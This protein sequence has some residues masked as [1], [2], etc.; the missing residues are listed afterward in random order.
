MDR[1]ILDG[2]RIVDLSEGRAGSLAALMLAEAGADVVKIVD[3]AHASRVTAADDAFWNRSK[4]RE[5]LDLTL[6]ADRRRLDTLLAGADMLIHDRIPQDAAALGLDDATLAQARPDLIVAGV[7][8]W[9]VGHPLD[10]MATDDALALA[11]AGFFDEQEA[12][13][14]DGP[15]FLRF[16]LGSAHAAHLIVIGALTRLYVRRMSGKG[17][18]VRTSLV[19]GALVPQMMNWHR[20]AEPTPAQAGAMPKN[21]V[22][23]IYQCGDGLWVH[24]MGPVYLSPSVAAGLAA[25]NEEDKARA[26][27]AYT[28]QGLLYAPNKGAIDAVMRT[29]PRSAWLEEFATNDVAHQPCLP[30]GALYDD[31]QVLANGYAVPVD[32]VAFGPTLQPATPFHITPPVALRAAP[33]LG[34]WP[35]KPGDAP[36]GDNPLPDRPLAGLRVL[37]FGNYLAGPFGPML[38]ADMGADVIKVEA[39]AGDPMRAGEWPFLGCQRGKRTI[40]LQLKDPKSREVLV[41]LIK[42]ADIVHHNTRLP[43]AARLGLDYESVKA[44]NP[45][46]IFCHV[47]TY[48]PEG[49]RKDWP[50]Y[51]QMV[52]A[53]SGWEYEGAGEGNPPIWH[54]FGMMD[55]QGALASVTATLLALLRRQQTGEGQSCSV[56]LLGAGMLSLLG[57]KRADGS[58]TPY[59]KL[60]SRQLGLS[61]ARRL[62]SCTDGWIVAA[63]SEAD[64]QSNDRLVRAAGMGAEGLEAHFAGLSMAQ[65]LTLLAQANIAGTQAK[66]DQRYPF[67]DSADNQRLGLIA[68]YPHPVY[69][70][71][72]QPGALLS[73]GD[74]A[75][76]LDRS[77]PVLGQHTRELLGE[78]GFDGEQIETLIRDGTALAA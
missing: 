57:I 8:A 14:R 17:G 59:A 48:G 67:F 13:G 33:D 78:L 5:T 10:A 27:A 18:V 11:S 38:M 12:V 34:R 28:P 62:Y 70:R 46:I 7:T 26:N 20:A 69:Q 3:P 41:R 24:V 35:T 56:S 6:A 4:A 15:N 39:T 40:A 68:S 30:M 2:V 22:P 9:P 42:S 74:M 61:P 58:L 45:N 71:L 75:L 21:N 55:H 77:P 66:R 64:T 47:G 49:A 16:P 60:D 50:G 72:E 31:G 65:A 23:T 52:Q 19:Q 32:T 53:V 44:I 63:A 54:R 43:A 36:H 1:A 76:A 29:R 51:D 25:M 73:F 37:D